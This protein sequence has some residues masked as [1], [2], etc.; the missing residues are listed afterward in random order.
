[1]HWRLP[2]EHSASGQF[3]SD[4]RLKPAPVGWATAAN[5]P[6]GVSSAPRTTEPLTPRAGLHAAAWARPA[7]MQ[8]LRQVR[9]HTARHCATETRREDAK[10]RG[11]Q[12]SVQSAT[13]CQGQASVTDPSR[14]GSRRR[15]LIV[16]APARR[17]SVALLRSRR[18]PARCTRRRPRRRTRRALHSGLRE[19]HRL[20]IAR[21]R[22]PGCRTERR[23]LH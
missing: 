18:T 14:Y 7:R 20:R 5:R 21:R 12:A 10:G 6:D 23:P 16:S 1:M 19:S 13:A 2:T 22:R 3:S 4:E 11:A 8:R 9:R 17:R 15:V